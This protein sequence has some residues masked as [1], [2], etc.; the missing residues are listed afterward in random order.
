MSE[1]VIKFK[2]EKTATAFVSWFC[3]SGEQDY[4]ISQEDVNKP[5]AKSFD[6]D[7]KNNIITEE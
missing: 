4:F 6:Y 2:D 3:N 5:M 1:V 7:F